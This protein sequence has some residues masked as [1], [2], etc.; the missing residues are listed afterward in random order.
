MLF[1]FIGPILL[2]STYSVFFLDFSVQFYGTVHRFYCKSFTASHSLPIFETC[3]NHVSLHCAILST[4]VLS[5]CR[6]LHTVSFFIRS[7]L[8]TRNNLLSHVISAFLRHQHFEPYNTIGITKVSYNFTLVVFEIFFKLN[9]TKT[10]KLASTAWATGCPCPS[11]LTTARV[12]IL[13]S[14]WLVGKALA[15][16]YFIRRQ[17]ECW[18]FDCKFEVSDMQVSLFSVVNRSCWLSAHIADLKV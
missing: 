17:L 12:Y 2:I 18:I 4:N 13:A 1:C 10:I 14:G 3:P 11:A 8:V 5:R 7:R 6:V 15:E 9:N 16:T